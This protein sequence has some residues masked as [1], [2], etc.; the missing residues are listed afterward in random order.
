LAESALLAL[1]LRLRIELTEPIYFAFNLSLSTAI[2]PAS[3]LDIMGCQGL[4]GL[5]AN[6]ESRV[7][8]T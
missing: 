1:D 5:G 4:E 6:R 2:W 7:T 8:S 3:S